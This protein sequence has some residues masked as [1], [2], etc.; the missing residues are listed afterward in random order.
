MDFPSILMAFATAVAVMLILRPLAFH[1]E[2]LDAPGGR[3]QHASHTPIVGGLAMFIGLMV[4]L[5][6][7]P[8]LPGTYRIF[9]LA[10]LWLVFFGFV[11]DHW[12]L[13]A[14][15]RFLIQIAAGL[16]MCL[17]ADVRLHTLGHLFFSHEV[18]LNIF[19]I[20]VTVF[21]VVI[22]VN[23]INFIDS[24]DGLA[25]SVVFII[26]SFIAFLAW[27]AGLFVQAQVLFLVLASLFSY[28]LFNSRLFGRKAA[29]V[30]MGD[31][32]S[33]FLGFVMVWFST[34]LSQGDHPAATP[35]TFL[36]LVAIP[37]YDVLFVTIRRWKHGESALKADRSHL[38]HVLEGLG[39]S[40]NQIVCR[41]SF[42]VLL[43]GL[44]GVVGYLWSV[45][46]GVM[47][48]A[49]IMAFLIYVFV[50]NYLW[51]KVSLSCQI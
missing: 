10:S 50:L 43:T 26:L 29:L 7:D 13:P 9:I 6:M 27:H 32:G 20:P 31:C 42:F 41:I 18:G 16:M 48:L 33:L 47:L 12:P 45:P 8:H 3:K 11:D 5:L 15:W 35:I 30:F 40:T 36:W 38:P 4:G 28:L 51:R 39:L 2:L 25:G 21:G 22:V 44:I 1:F 49:F 14:R 34:R 24:L 37:I 17:G 46:E 19:S 23:A